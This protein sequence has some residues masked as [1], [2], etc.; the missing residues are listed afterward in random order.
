MGKARGLGW[1]VLVAV[2]GCGSRE[3]SQP[4]A[5]PPVEATTQAERAEA[6][7]APVPSVEPPPATPISIELDDGNGEVER[8][9]LTATASG[10]TASCPTVTVT[11]REATRGDLTPDA[12]AELVSFCR[13]GEDGQ[14]AVVVSSPAAVRWAQVLGGDCELGP[15]VSV[16]VVS[17]VEDASRELL[18]HLALCHQV[19]RIR[20]EDRLLRWRDGDFVEIARAEVDCDFRGDT[21]GESEDEGP[22]DYQ[23]TGGYLTIAPGPRPATV[24]TVGCTECIVGE[25]GS[26]RI[27]TEPG[28]VLTTR[29]WSPSD[30]AFVAQAPAAP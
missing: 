22:N 13:V 6:P 8:C 9:S 20:D 17:A 28:T 2:V 3:E 12:G 7:P 14:T 10:V 23:C 30:A 18:V 26:A 11:C 29:R 5:P 16:E 19:A 25:P 4:P 21:S 15:Q 1:V 27:L 24:T